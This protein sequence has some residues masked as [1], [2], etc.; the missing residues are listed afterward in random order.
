MGG[1]F[2]LLSR[3]G[4]PIAMPVLD[5]LSTGM[6]GW[7]RCETWRA[8]CAGLGRTNGSAGLEAY[9]EPKLADNIVCVAAGRV[10]NL[11]ELSLQLSMAPCRSVTDAE[12]IRHAYLKWGED[13]VRHIYGDWSFAVWH[14]A[15]RKLIVARDH[16]GNTSLYYY[17]DDRVFAFASDQRALWALN[18]APIE[19]DELYLAQVLVSWHGHHG[20]RT[21]HKP[22]HRLP[23]AH[24][25]TVTPDRFHIREY[26]R[27]EDTPVLRLPRREDYIPAFR[28]VFD[29]AVRARLRGP[30]SDL[31]DSGVKDGI[32][33]TL[34]GGLDSGSVTATAA[35]LLKPSGKRITA[36]TAVPLSDTSSYVGPHFGDEL[37]FASAT[38]QFAGNVDHVQ[39]AAAT[40][41]PVEGM[42][43][44]LEIHCEPCHAAGN[45][46]WLYDLEKSVAGQGYRIL[47][48]GQMGNGSV[49][50]P[51]DILSQPLACQVRFWGYRGTAKENL[52]QVAP[53]KL[54]K[55]WRHHHTPADWFRGYAIHPDFAKRLHLLEQRM[56]DPLEFPRTPLEKRCQFL[57]PG[58]L[59]LG[60][61]Q[62]EAGAAHGLELRD[63]TADARVVAFTISVPD[64]VFI[65]P[66]TGLSR[67]LIREA[68]KNRLPDVVRLNHMRGR[69]A[70]DLVPRL[71][72][73]AD[74]V[75]AAL[76]ELQ[77]GPAAEYVD[78]RHM[79]GVWEMIRT[80][81]TS[82]AFQ[83][84]VTVLT[85][86][87]M[88]GLWVNDFYNAHSTA[89]RKPL[90]NR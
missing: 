38:A 43:R 56:N 46:Y 47:L 81:D 17:A 80:R 85:C 20:T 45:L 49:S 21:I 16:Y 33:V 82:E 65:D 11:K 86:G 2:G 39:L 41:T 28:E 73:S 53:L 30:H 44:M 61:L 90:I 26:W 50:W 9:Y 77:R 42:R 72:A 69:Q 68:M 7:G 48:N 37:P 15:D 5:T 84:A 23:P 6:A 51:G 64:D 31:E 62:A 57:Q 74:E 25:L 63:P 75:N 89:N 4:N 12:L 40:I 24:L 18:L 52:K 70:G 55:F 32:A 14:P 78:V 3:D 88:A 22:I 60:A 10:D 27:L 76:D 66:K 29:E 83:K 87:I 54:V 71:R 35:R 59:L 79:R 1:I 36:F 8:G 67:W 58:R 19:M 13:C 34:S